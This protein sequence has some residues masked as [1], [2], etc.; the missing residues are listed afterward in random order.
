MDEEPKFPTQEQ[1][2]R[3]FDQIIDGLGYPVIPALPGLVFR[4]L[5]LGERGEASR[6]FSRFLVEDMAKGGRFSEPLLMTELRRRCLEVGAN[7]DDL[8]AAEE[9]FKKRIYDESPPDLSG[10]ARRLTDE[11]LAV[12]APEARDAYIAQLRERAN[13][14]REFLANLFTPE[15]KIVRGQIEQVKN[16]Q[17]NLQAN[18]YEHHARVHRRLTEI[19]SGARRE[20]PGTPADRWPPYFGSLEELYD[21]GDTDEATWLTLCAKWV[22][23]REGRWPGFTPRPSSI[24]TP[25]AG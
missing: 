10:E 2:E 23:F 4:R 12:M 3:R 17:A 7:Y 8:M 15:E 1:I 19:L 18:T 9:A 11:E 6:A 24:P 21:L 25:G 16:L 13:R 14:I 22:E 20:V 5:N